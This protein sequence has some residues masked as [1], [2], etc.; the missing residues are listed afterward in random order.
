MSKV[1]DFKEGDYST[2]MNALKQFLKGATLNHD[3]IDG[4]SN[5]TNG[6]KWQDIP[7]NKYILYPNLITR[8]QSP[9]D[10]NQPVTYTTT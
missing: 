4:L 8:P 5:D 9:I 6:S 1:F 2:T 10:P 7:D 3:I